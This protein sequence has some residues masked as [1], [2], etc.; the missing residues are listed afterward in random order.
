MFHE[1]WDILSWHY[2]RRTVV[3]KGLRL[4]D[5]PHG[6]TGPASN[7]IELYQVTAVTFR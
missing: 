6:Q 3:L 2:V 7:G 5:P 4:F 1:T